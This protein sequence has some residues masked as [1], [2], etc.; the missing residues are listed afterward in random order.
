MKRKLE[1]EGHV[2]QKMWKN[3]Y[4][5]VVQ[6]NCASL[7]IREYQ[8]QKSTICIIIMKQCTKRSLDILKANY[9]RINS[10][11]LSHICNSNIM[12][13]LWLKK[14]GEAEVYVSFALL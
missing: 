8:C 12:Y 1:D 11:F 10:T 6:K 5:S 4:F 2:F 9:G 3:M 7:V 13:L 14:S